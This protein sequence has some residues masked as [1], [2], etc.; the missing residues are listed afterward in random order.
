MASKNNLSGKMNTMMKLEIYQ[1]QM[2][3]D[4]KD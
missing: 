4:I 1:I 2:I 3:R